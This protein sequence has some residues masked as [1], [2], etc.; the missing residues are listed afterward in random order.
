ME[1]H[2]LLGLTRLLVAA[3]IVNVLVHWLVVCPRLYRAGSRFPTGFLPWR[4]FK[5]MAMYEDLC[6]A[7][8]DSLTSFY[9]IYLG[10]WF[11]FLLGVVVGFVWL[12]R[13]QQPLR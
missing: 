13:S 2:V 1:D 7:R 3:F 9:L 6:R 5:E 11:T 12:A 10:L 8:G 4:I